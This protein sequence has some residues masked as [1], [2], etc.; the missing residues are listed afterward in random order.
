MQWIARPAAP[1]DQ[2]LAEA[3]EIAGLV[4]NASEITPNVL[5]LLL[6]AQ[7]E[8]IARCGKEAFR[9]S[10]EQRQQLAGLIAQSLSI[11]VEECESV[12][13]ETGESLRKTRLLLGAVQD[14]SRLYA[15]PSAASLSPAKVARSPQRQAHSSQKQKAQKQQQ[16]QKVGQQ[17]K[18][19]AA[20]ESEAADAVVVSPPPP[21][22]PPPVVEPARFIEPMNPQPANTGLDAMVAAGLDAKALEIDDAQLVA[23]VVDKVASNTVAFKANK[24]PQIVAALVREEFMQ[25]AVNATKKALDPNLTGH[26][27]VSAFVEWWPTT[28]FA[29]AACENAWMRELNTEALRTRLMSEALHRQLEAQNALEQKAIEEAREQRRQKEHLAS[30]PKRVQA[31]LGRLR[32][33]EAAVQEV[34][35]HAMR[36]ALIA[37]EELADVSP[38]FL[39]DLHA[40][41]S[42]S[43]PLMLRAKGGPF[44]QLVHHKARTSLL[45]EELDSCAAAEVRARKEASGAIEVYI[46]RAEAMHKR[47]HNRSATQCADWLRQGV[48]RAADAGQKVQARHLIDN[49]TRRVKLALEAM[50][51]WLD[52]PAKERV[53]LLP[54]RFDELAK[55]TLV[56]VVKHQLPQVG[57]HTRHRRATQMELSAQLA[58]ALEPKHAKEVEELH[59]TLEALS[60]S[61]NPRESMPIDEHTQLLLSELWFRQR[62]Q[63]AKLHSLEQTA[64]PTMVRHFVDSLSCL[65]YTSPSPRDRQKSRM[66]SS[67]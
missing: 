28:R 6:E 14:N 62:A 66:P 30:Q 37:V 17:Q 39:H 59:T 46:E 63:L 20:P 10:E 34:H 57:G 9:Q 52:G 7:S 45:V 15:E 44:A 1:R 50:S 24:L 53:K 64:L 27:E 58:R 67:A 8:L 38:E 21:P 36:E 40:Q 54:L 31:V 16:Q 12:P 23:F 19:P 42:A 56:H 49:E 4:E 47:L 48:R 55:S 5:Q 65:L 26:I 18:R 2:A 61:L 25:A 3:T 29:S 33:A 11:L 13:A 60:A 22:P 35:S 51:E 41:L 43:S 32:R